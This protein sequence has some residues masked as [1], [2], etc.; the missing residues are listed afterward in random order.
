MVNPHA[1][2]TTRTDKYNDLRTRQQIAASPIP[3]ADS[4]GCSRPRGQL[5]SEACWTLVTAP[6]PGAGD[7]LWGLPCIPIPAKIRKGFSLLYS[8]IE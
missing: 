5:A 7:L 2:I 8:L 4:C 6:G 3:C 1:P